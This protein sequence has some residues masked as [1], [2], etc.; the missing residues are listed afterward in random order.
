MADMYK[1]HVEGSVATGRTTDPSLVNRHHLSQLIRHA[2]KNAGTSA[3]RVNRSHSQTGLRGPATA[4]MD[5]APV[6]P[7]RSR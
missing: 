5:L 4:L 6:F 2:D 1:H 3:P 7:L